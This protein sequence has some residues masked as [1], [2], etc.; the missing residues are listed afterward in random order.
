V[1]RAA[2]DITGFGLLG[3]A[4][5]LA[6]ASG[7]TLELRV[8][9]RLFLPRVL[10]LAEAGVVPGGLARNREHYSR[11]IALRA[12]ERVPGRAIESAVGSTTDGAVAIEPA[13][14]DALYDPQTS[15]GLFVS[16][17]E[18]MAVAFERGLAKR[19]VPCI[20]AGRARKRGRHAV[21]LSGA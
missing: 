3:H 16:V 19:R 2:T 8:S 9:P 17:P 20:D 21:V 5:Q 6:D 10:E 12:T 11:S 18:R 14:L 15:G 7:V 1:A 4:T 13:M